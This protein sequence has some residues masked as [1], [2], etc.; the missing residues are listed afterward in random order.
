MKQEYIA[1]MAERVLVETFDLCSYDDGCGFADKSFWYDPILLERE[2]IEDFRDQEQD[3]GITSFVDL[4]GIYYG[5]REK[6]F[7]IYMRGFDH[8]LFLRE[9]AGSGVG[10]RTVT[11]ITT[12]ENNVVLLKLFKIE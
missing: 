9:L 8:D 11:D 4:K 1:E 5:S 7:H 6:G 10:L 2:E 3:D 12:M